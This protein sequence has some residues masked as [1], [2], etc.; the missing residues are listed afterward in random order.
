[1]KALDADLD[2]A[3]ATFEDSLRS[4]EKIVRELEQGNLPL[5][6]SIEQYS[7]AAKHLKLC[8]EKLSK[9]ER[10]VQLLRGVDAN[11]QIDSVDLDDT[12]QSLEDRQAK[13]SQRRSANFE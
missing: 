7:H 10:Q 8:Y 12:A 3:D 9:A 11:G 6:E 2:L 4:L 5:E 13:R 1:M